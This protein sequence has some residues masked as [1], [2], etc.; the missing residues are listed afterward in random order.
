MQ[1]FIHDFDQPSGQQITLPEAGRLS[2]GKKDEERGHPVKLDY[3]RVYG[4][5]MATVAAFRKRYGEKPT[6]LEVTFLTSDPMQVCRTQYQLR[7]GSQKYAYGDGQTFMHWHVEDWNQPDRKGRMVQVVVN[8]AAE[9][10]QLMERLEQEA[11]KVA[12][13]KQM[14]P[15]TIK[16][17][18]WKMRLTLQLY[19]PGIGVA[20]TWIFG[21]GGEATSI[22]KIVGVF[23][24][25]L[26]S[27]K[28]VQFM[29][30]K[31][32]VRIVDGDTM[33]R[34][35]Y[36]MVELIPPSAKA[37]AVAGQ[38]GAKL[39]EDLYGKAIVG[40]TEEQLLAAGERLELQA[41]TGVQYN[42][43]PVQEDV[44]EPAP[45]MESMADSYFEEAPAESSTE[46]A[47]EHEPEP[48]TFAWFLK[49]VRR[50]ATWS[51]LVERWQ[52]AK[53]HHAKAALRQ[54]YA[55]RAAQLAPD[56]T[57]LYALVDTYTEL[58]QVAA[59]T[60]AVKQRKATKG[61]KRPTQ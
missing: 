59:F 2:V 40:L 60:D 29:P 17:T 53:K 15:A 21:T 61:W 8:T 10:D 46:A 20:G 24:T 38:Y 41:A 45:L 37:M 43:A 56:A 18:K 16:Q 31:L 54:A 52:E 44:P 11:V 9:R 49:E 19:L 1:A 58:H 39:F 33:E 23:R 13:F 48:G 30:F 28:T 32:R 51:L 3:F 55:I 34:K 4:A 22:K 36:P 25:V 35:K 5:D 12:Q 7:C 27:A 26:L 47:G 50:A 57:T 14:R 6:E 42:A